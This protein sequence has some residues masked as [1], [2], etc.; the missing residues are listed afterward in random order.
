MLMVK[1]INAP[2][3]NLIALDVTIL[4][5]QALGELMH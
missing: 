4:L 1:D 3:P 2:L 5:L